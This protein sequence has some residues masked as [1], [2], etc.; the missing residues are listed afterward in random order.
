[1]LFYFA[2]GALNV[3]LLYI[4]SELFKRRTDID[5]FPGRENGDKLEMGLNIAA[6]FSRDISARWRFV[7][8]VCFY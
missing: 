2:L 4:F 7:C 3:V 6:F 5:L 8:L 1:M